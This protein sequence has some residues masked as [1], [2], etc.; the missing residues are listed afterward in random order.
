MPLLA[1]ATV[2][3]QA[4]QL[5]ADLMPHGAGK[6]T[7]TPHPATAGTA[8]TRPGGLMVDQNPPQRVDGARVL[9]GLLQF[10]EIGPG[11]G[12]GVATGPFPG[13]PFRTRRMCFRIPGSPRVLPVG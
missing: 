7:A 2:G 6:A 4:K 11:R 12:A 5:A 10:G 1:V 13:T 3:Q 9:T 8:S